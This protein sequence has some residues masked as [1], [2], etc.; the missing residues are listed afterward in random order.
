M[1]VTPRRHDAPMCDCPTDDDLFR[2][3]DQQIDAGHW[4]RIG[5]GFGEDP[6]PT[7]WTYTIGLTELFG[8]PELCIVGMCCWTCSSELL[9]AVSERVRTGA[10]F[11]RS[12]LPVVVGDRRGDVEVATRPV[13]PVALETSW[14]AVWRRYYGSKPWAPPPLEVVQIVLPDTH[15][16]YPWDDACD[17]EIVARQA[18]PASPPGSNRATRRRARR[19]RPRR[20]R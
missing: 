11:G 18:M 2:A 19:H 17:P 7:P 4:Y 9:S 5:V 12:P 20:H 3:I 13:H 16:C 10:L 6:S 15:G 8:H 1:N 14:F